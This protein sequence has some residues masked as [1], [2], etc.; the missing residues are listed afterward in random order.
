MQN[1]SPPRG[2]RIKNH[3]LAYVDNIRHKSVRR[4]TISLP[5]ASRALREVAVDTALVANAIRPYD[6]GL[7][8]PLLRLLL[9]PRHRVCSSSTH[10]SQPSTVLTPRQQRIPAAGIGGIAAGVVRI[11]ASPFARIRDDKTRRP[12]RRSQRRNQ[13]HKR[14]G[15]Q[16]SYWHWYCQWQS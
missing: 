9:H 4:V 15:A 1:W 8:T 3:D 11:T 2:S 10:L 12:T 13:R 5:H 7:P 6:A 14:R 16:R